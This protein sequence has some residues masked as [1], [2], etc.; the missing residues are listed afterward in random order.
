MHLLR[1]RS[2]VA[3]FA[4]AACSTGVGPEDGSGTPPPPPVGCLPPAS[5]DTP[6]GPGTTPPTEFSAA[7]LS[8]P[9]LA[10]LVNP[11]LAGN[12]VFASL[13]PGTVPDGV[14]LTLVNHRTGARASAPFLLGGVDPVA[15]PA[16]RGDTIGFIVFTT[17]LPAGAVE[18]VKIVP[19]SRAPVVVRTEPVQ[20]LRTFP[21]NAGIAVVFSESMD[22]GSLTEGSLQLQKGGV[23]VR[24]TITLEDRY[25]LR[26]I[27][28]PSA[29]LVPSTDYVI[30]ATAGIQ[31]IAGTPLAAPVSVAFTSAVATLTEYDSYATGPFGLSLS[32]C[33]F[34]SDGTFTLQRWENGSYKFYSGHFQATATDINF[35]FDGESHPGPWQATARRSG[36]T[37][38]VTFNA[39]MQMAGFEDGPFA[40]EDGEPLP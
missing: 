6:V 12:L 1:L 22:P 38:T 16:I 31:D 24:G 32:V 15:L 5:C 17:V 14:S 28:T 2:L 34:W 18:K 11:E 8:E 27:F 37:F 10:V 35:L 4:F 20:G 33:F 13:P 19:A 36:S 40:L 30:T 3:C 9:V 7:I 29:L 23:L 21:L 39:L 26:V 25:H